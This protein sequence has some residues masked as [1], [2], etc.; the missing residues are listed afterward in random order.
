MLLFL[1]NIW[2]LTDKAKQSSSVTRIPYST[3]QYSTVQ[4]SA[5]Q[6]STAPA[7]GVHAVQVKVL[8][9]H[10]ALDHLGHCGAVAA[11]SVQHEPGGHSLE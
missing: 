11:L 6:Y 4:C 10:I 9:V 7:Q 8:P 5:V 2:Y 3:V 1:R